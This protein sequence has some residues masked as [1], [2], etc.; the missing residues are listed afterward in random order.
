MK[1]FYVILGAAL[2]LAGFVILLTMYSVGDASK[3]L[4]IAA[5]LG[6]IIGLLYYGK[7][8]H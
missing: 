3:A 5:F 4:G 1:N 2:V 6:A 7:S 8:K